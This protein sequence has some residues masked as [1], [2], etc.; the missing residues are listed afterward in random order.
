MITRFAYSHE[1]SA[2]SEQ[3]SISNVQLDSVNFVVAKNAT[4][5][6]RLLR[7]I[8]ALCE[9]I[10]GN[11][12]VFFGHW[13]VSFTFNK[14]SYDYSIGTKD[15]EVYESLLIDKIDVMRRTGKNASLYSHAAK[16]MVTVAPPSDKLVMNYRRDQVEY[17]YFEDL[18]QFASNA[19]LFKFGMLHSTD[20]MTDDGRSL[21][22]K[23]IDDVATILQTELS[24]ADRNIVCTTLNALGYEVEQIDVKIIS[25][26]PK[27][28]VKEK[29]LLYPIEQRLLSQGMFRV[30]AIAV[31][32]QYMKVKIQP[33]LIMVDDVG[34][35]LDYDRARR[36]ATFLLGYF[37]DSSIQAVLT[38]NHNFFLDQVSL[39]H[40]LIL[41]K[42]GTE[43][44]GMSA[45]SHPDVFNNFRLSGLAPFDIFSSNYLNAD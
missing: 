34:E 5:K 6:S 16:G 27:I 28:T 18:Y 45:V 23:G 17:P 10:T 24:E 25:G 19:R 42:K 3:W 35:G 36:L 38:S 14:Q 8:E 32:L 20:F 29:G 21:K 9:M 2:R 26:A 43:V 44:S 39:K 41:R 30:I 37:K 12:T 4:G 7:A 15:G 22:A 1:T 31:Y 13:S 11:T 40:W 33:S